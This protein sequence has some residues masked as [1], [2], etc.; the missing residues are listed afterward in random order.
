MMIGCKQ[1]ENFRDAMY[2]CNLVKCSNHMGVLECSQ[3]QR[4]QRDWGSR[5]ADFT[6]LA[7][8]FLAAQ[9][10]TTTPYSSTKETF[11]SAMTA[12]DGR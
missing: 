3:V 10:Q 12:V 6:A 2:A 5:V 11:R 4:G 7:L 1:G 9:S 8:G